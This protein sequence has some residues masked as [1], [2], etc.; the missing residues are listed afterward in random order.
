MRFGRKRWEPYRWDELAIYNS[1]V[2]RGIVHTP[3]KV[4][5]MAEQQRQFNAE[6]EEM[7]AELRRKGLPA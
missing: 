6:T 1:E 5:Q 3:A 7:I 2:Y 4:A